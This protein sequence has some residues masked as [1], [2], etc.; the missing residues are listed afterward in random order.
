[1]LSA[2]FH[3]AIPRLQADSAGQLARGAA[4]VAGLEG[5]NGCPPVLL[6][7]IRKLV[8][9]PHI[10]RSLLPCVLTWLVYSD[11][12]RRAKV[13]YP[14]LVSELRFGCCALRDEHI[15]ALAA[16]IQSSECCLE[17]RSALTLLR[18]ICLT[19]QALSQ[20]LDLSF[21]RITDVGLA[22]LCDAVRSEGSTQL[23]Q[24]PCLACTHACI[25]IP[26]QSISVYILSQL[27]LGGND[28]SSESRE[29]QAEALR[30]SCPLLQVEWEPRL[31]K[32]LSLAT[33]GLVYKN[34]PA[35]SA[36]LMQGDR[37]VAWGMLQK[38]CGLHER[39][40]FQPNYG[41]DSSEQFLTSCRFE[42]VRSASF[43][44]RLHTTNTISDLI[45]LF[46]V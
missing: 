17:A 18:L 22:Q 38:G 27:Y 37:I 24:A 43:D 44:R 31:H 2:S 35:Q 5:M 32:A 12:D 29:L 25:D 30:R 16:T 20:T 36:G 14:K 9:T 41:S 1:M 11:L 8:S 6:Y 21:N 42:S 45:T 23:S 4:V 10:S 26:R 33:V 34:S 46:S 19:R 40:G 15:P 13:S 28:T 39:F 3:E 7:A